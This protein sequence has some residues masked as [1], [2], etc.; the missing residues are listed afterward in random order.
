MDISYISNCIARKT[1]NLAL[2]MITV[3]ISAS[4]LPASA[5][6]I[7]RD[8]LTLNYDASEYDVRAENDKR[9]W[10][11]TG[12]FAEK[13]EKNKYD[14]QLGKKVKRITRENGLVTGFSG[15]TGAYVFR[16]IGSNEGNNKATAL[17]YESITGN[18]TDNSASFE[19]WFRPESLTNGNQVLWETGGGVDGSSFTI[20]NGKLRFT[21]KDGTRVDEKLVSE[22]NLF[23]ETPILST[24]E[25][26][27]AVA[28]YDSL[29]GSL[30][31]YL[32]GELVGT[33]TND[34]VNDWAGGNASGLGGL[35]GNTG[36][37]GAGGV[38]LNLDPFK[39]DIAIVR[40]YETELSESDVKQNF[41][42]IAEIP[43]T[44]SPLSL[45]ALGSLGGG[46]ILLRKNK[47]LREATG[48]SGK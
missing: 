45:L 14:W 39:G 17:S 34:N 3:A 2:A 15:I 6:T 10:E 13:D 21:M 35:N 44:S 48:N 24:R 7:I 22:E 29:N 27:Q 37:T 43:E 12:S 25:F 32:N 11:N 23:I 4:A 40:F 28:T 31:L 46:S 5:A 38:N 33:D 9:F 47:K 42:A 19:I 16:D 26:I 8:S 30:S 1:G 18:P 41:N 36:G 20:L